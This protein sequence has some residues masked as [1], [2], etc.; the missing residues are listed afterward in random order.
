[1][2]VTISLQAH[3]KGCELRSMAAHGRDL[4]AVM[5]CCD[6]TTISAVTDPLTSHIKPDVHRLVCSITFERWSHHQV[7]KGCVG[8]AA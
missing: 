4:Q 5:T 1:M 2:V 8:Y 7:Y 3:A 6:A